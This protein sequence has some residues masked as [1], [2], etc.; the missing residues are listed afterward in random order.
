MNFL[1]RHFMAS[2]PL[3]AANMA[4][5]RSQRRINQADLILQEELDNGANND[6]GTPTNKTIMAANNKHVDTLE[7]NY[8]LNAEKSI[9]T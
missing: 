1:P 6:T 4:T 2:W 8:E 7:A 5:T 3:P 9:A